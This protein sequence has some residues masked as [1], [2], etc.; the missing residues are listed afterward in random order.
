M[1]YTEIKAKKNLAFLTSNLQMGRMLNKKRRKLKHGQWLL[2]VR[3]YCGISQPTAWR[4]M[5]K[6]TR[7]EE[8]ANG[9]NARAKELLGYLCG[10]ER[11][12]RDGEKGKIPILS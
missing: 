3:D 12:T 4:W 1:G 6:A 5:D 9:G 8:S 2:F 10:I 11:A 7:L